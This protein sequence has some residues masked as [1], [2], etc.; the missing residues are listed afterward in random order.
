MSFALRDPVR[1]V[2]TDKPQIT[3]LIW[4]VGH[5]L[6]QHR[7]IFDVYDVETQRL[8]QNLEAGELAAL[9]ENPFANKIGQHL[10]EAEVDKLAARR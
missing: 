8:H 10:T 5:D 1:V 9:E 4:G 3:G 7:A 6:T 2:A